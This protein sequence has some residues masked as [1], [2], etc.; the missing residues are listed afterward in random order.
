MDLRGAIPARDALTAML[1]RK[2]IPAEIARGM[3][4]Q[5]FSDIEDSPDSGPR[6][7]HLLHFQFI[8]EIVDGQYWIQRDEFERALATV[9]LDP[10]LA[11][12]FRSA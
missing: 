1:E 12:H 2:G 9:S 11:D 4:S 6:W 10:H 8:A 5:S 3:A 7:V